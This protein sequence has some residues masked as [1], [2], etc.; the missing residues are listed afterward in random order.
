MKLLRG[1]ISKE[2][3]AEHP[4]ATAPGAVADLDQAE[5]DDQIA[6]LREAVEA[7]LDARARAA[8]ILAV[9]LAANGQGDGIA[10]TGP[11]RLDRYAVATI[12]WT[13]A[14]WIAGLG[15]AAIVG[16]LVAYFIQ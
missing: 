14:F 5:I 7:E 15:V 1:R 12:S 9:P 13:L 11:R 2:L 8:S 16:I 6:A 10:S 4:V 3:H